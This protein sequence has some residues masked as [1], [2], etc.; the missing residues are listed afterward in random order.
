MN[1]LVTVGGRDPDKLRFKHPVV[2]GDRLT[3]QA[4]ILSEKRGIW[5]FSCNAKVD[6]KLVCSGDI[7]CADRQR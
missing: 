7:L 4:E 5:K 2:P 6:G 3:L 1:R